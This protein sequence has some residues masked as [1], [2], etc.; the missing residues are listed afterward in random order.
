[1]IGCQTGNNRLYQRWIF[2]SWNVSSAQC[3]MTGCH[4]DVAVGLLHW[5]G[6]LH[7]G[8]K[9]KSMLIDEIAMSWQFKIRPELWKNL[10]SVFSFFFLWVVLRCGIMKVSYQCRL[11]WSFECGHTRLQG[12]HKKKINQADLTTIW[13]NFEIVFVTYVTYFQF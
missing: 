3:I 11:W 10:F 13:F 4:L 8:V 6:L 1:M 12:L 7:I 9:F 2:V 5:N